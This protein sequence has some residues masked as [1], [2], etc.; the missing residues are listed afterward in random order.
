M[1]KIIQLFTTALLIIT[2]ANAGWFNNDDKPKTT[3]QYNTIQLT[4]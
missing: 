4:P 3:I 2:T 1:K